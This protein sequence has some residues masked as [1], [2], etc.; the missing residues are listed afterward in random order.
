MR[1]KRA[2]DPASP[3]DGYRIL[4]DRLWP[5]G[6]TKENLQADNW[7]KEVAPSTGLRKEFHSEKID[8]QSFRKKYEAELQGPSAAAFEE[9]K[10]LVKQ[11]ATVTLLFASKSEE[12]NHA[13]I[14][15]KL[16]KG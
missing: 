4:I 6:I 9:L 16:L 2:Y 13:L 14:L 5:R 10:K 11:H 1:I 12:Q 8:W 7:L 3:S 15:Q